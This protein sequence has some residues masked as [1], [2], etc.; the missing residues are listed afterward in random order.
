MAT[1][2][3]RDLSC[4]TDLDPAMREV[5]G[6]DVMTQAIARRLGTP[7]GWVIDDPNYGYDLRD[8]L[9]AEGDRTAPATIAARARAEILKDER[10]QSADASVVSSGPPG[11]T[12]ITVEVNGVAAEGPFDLTLAVSAVTLEILKQAVSP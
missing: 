11:A 12:S 6:V 9:S 4:V 7:R 1:D 10:V 5:T 2:F 8:E 3:G